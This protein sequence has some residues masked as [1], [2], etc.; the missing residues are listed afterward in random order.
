M[1]SGNNSLVTDYVHSFWAIFWVDA[2]SR[3]SLERGFIDIA[4]K[5]DIQDRSLDGA[6]LWLANIDKR[7]LC[8]LDNA[9]DRKIDY[10]AYFPSGHRGSIIITTR[11]QDCSI[12]NTVGH[13]TLIELETEDATKLLLKVSGVSQDLWQIRHHAAEKAVD[14]LG[15][16][17]GFDKHHLWNAFEMQKC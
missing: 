11:N 2:S 16:A 4:N 5:C 12:H 15:V 10:A 6:K 14:I 1:L 3:A 7:W 17:P 13:E 9:D 8:I